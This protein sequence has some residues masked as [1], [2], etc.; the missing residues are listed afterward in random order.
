[1]Q[2][3]KKIARVCWLSN[4][5]STNKDGNKKLSIWQFGNIIETNLRYDFASRPI[6]PTWNWW[7]ASSKGG[8]LNAMGSHQIDLLRWWLGEPSK[9]LGT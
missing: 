6:K 7:S 2:T 5:I 4:E 8:V 3:S 1:M 9:V